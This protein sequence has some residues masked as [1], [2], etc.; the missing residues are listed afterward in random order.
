MPPPLGLALARRWQADGT[1]VRLIGAVR[2]EGMARR[3]LANGLFGGRARHQDEGYH[4]WLPLPEGIRAADLATA[5]LPVVAGTTFAADGRGAYEALRLSLGGARSRERL[6]R[7]LRR[8]DGIIAGA[9][10]RD[11]TLV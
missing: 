6:G 7:D 2:Q 4:L 1:L 11:R 3:Q 10:R 8:L 5:G 9:T